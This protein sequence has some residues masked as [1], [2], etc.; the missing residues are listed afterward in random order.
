V[1]VCSE[2]SDSNSLDNNSVHGYIDDAV[3]GEVADDEQE[4]VMNLYGSEGEDN[5]GDHVMP[6]GDNNLAAVLAQ[7]DQERMEGQ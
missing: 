4:V 1:H 2:L 7:H 5:W 3:R 6:R